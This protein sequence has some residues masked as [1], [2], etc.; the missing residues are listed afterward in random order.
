MLI[1]GRCC[2][3]CNWINTGIAADDAVAV[4]D[5]VAGAAGAADIAPATCAVA[6]SASAE[7]RDDSAEPCVERQKG[8]LH[9]CL[10]TRQN[11]GNNVRMCIY[12]CV[13]IHI[14]VD[15]N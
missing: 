7:P 10:P 5:G 1:G 2:R 13:C 3:F 9:Y 12:M 11:N 15:E 8:I 4:F 6:E 14:Y